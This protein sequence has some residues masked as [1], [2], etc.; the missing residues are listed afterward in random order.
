M[1]TLKSVSRESVYFTGSRRH[2]VRTVYAENDKFFVKWY[3]EFIEVKK[4][5]FGYV[6]VFQY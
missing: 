1:A 5:R 2:Y 6:T 4:T 3:G